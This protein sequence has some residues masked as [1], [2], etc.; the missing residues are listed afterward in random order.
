MIYLTLPGRADPV[1]L[2]VSNISTR[3]NL[4]EVYAYV[5]ECIPSTRGVVIVNDDGVRVDAVEMYGSYAV[6]IVPELEICQR[7]YEDCV[8]VW[9][10]RGPFDIAPFV[11]NTFMVLEN[12]FDVTIPDVSIPVAFQDVVDRYLIV[13]TRLIEMHEMSRTNANQEK[14]MGMENELFVSITLFYISYCQYYHSCCR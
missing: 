3:S 7:A 11:S 12:A 4:S 5:R 14:T 2:D 10:S 13:E 1:E 8:T 9:K 6:K